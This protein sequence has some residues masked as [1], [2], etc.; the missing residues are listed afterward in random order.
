M[1]KFDE[2]QNPESCLNK[3]TKYEMLFI[4]LQRDEA[5]PAAIHAWVEKRIELGKNKRTDPQILDALNC[6]LYMGAHR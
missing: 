3:A 1:L 4:L 5:A 2:I 6:A